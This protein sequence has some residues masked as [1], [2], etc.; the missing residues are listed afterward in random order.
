MCH[1]GKKRQVASALIKK[2]QIASANM[3]NGQI[4]CAIMKK[5]S[6]NILSW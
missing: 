2:R 4:V 1:H 3:E 5:D 6:E